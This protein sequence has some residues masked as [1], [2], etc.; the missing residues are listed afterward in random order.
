M[1]AAISIVPR[2]KPDERI[3]CICPVPLA[4]EEFLGK[5]RSEER[6]RRNIRLFLRGVN[7]RL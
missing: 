3:E 1:S 5:I 4:P 2:T 6:D 7:C